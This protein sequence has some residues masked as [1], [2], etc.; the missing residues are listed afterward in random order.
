V[1]D[2]EV[3]VEPASAPVVVAALAVALVHVVEAAGEEPE[4]AAVAVVVEVVWVVA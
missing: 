3:A 2:L 1:A 4:E